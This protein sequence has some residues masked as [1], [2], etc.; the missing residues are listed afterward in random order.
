MRPI[1]WLFLSILRALAATAFDDGQGVPSER[2]D[3]LM[4]EYREFSRSLGAK[5]R[6]AFCLAILALQFLPLFVIGVPLPMTW[7]P[8]RLRVKYLEKLEAGPLT[9]IV[10]ATKVPLTMIYFEHPEVMAST[11]YDG[12]PLVL[13]GEESA[14]GGLPAAARKARLQTLP[15]LAELR[16]RE[17]AR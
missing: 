5:T 2:L 14:S 15:A 17:V 13:T 16:A 10:T 8:G 11:G 9:A 1:G 3:W 6:T 4:R 12:R 7:L